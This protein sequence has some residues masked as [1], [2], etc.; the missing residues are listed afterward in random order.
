MNIVIDVLS[1]RRDQSSTVE[2]L[3]ASLEWR[4]AAKGE[5][6]LMRGHAVSQ[7]ADIVLLKVAVYA[8]EAQRIFDQGGYVLTPPQRAVRPRRRIGRRRGVTRA[9][10][11]LC[12][13]TFYN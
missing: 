9:T 7:A 8:A 10:R 2:T 1:L 11:Q 13:A 3:L 5:R 4:D 6:S 12:F